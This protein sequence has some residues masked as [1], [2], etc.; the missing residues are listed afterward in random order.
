[1]IIQNSLIFLLFLTALGCTSTRPQ[2]TLVETDLV[3]PTSKKYDYK[4]KFTTPTFPGVIQS[5]S[6]TKTL[7]GG[8]PTI[9]SG[10]Q[11]SANYELSPHLSFGPVIGFQKFKP[12]NLSIIKVGFITR[13]Y[14]TDR[15]G[16]FLIAQGGADLP[17]KR[18]QFEI[19]SNVR[20]GIGYPVWKK[21]NTNLNLSL[22]YDRH[23]VN[24]QGTPAR[25]IFDFPQ[26]YRLES[27]GI[28]F[29][30]HFLGKLPK[31]KTYHKYLPEHRKL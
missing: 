4:I 3:I 5:V 29:G 21:D 22:F 6:D 28:G 19:G 18:S 14:F 7:S 16:L 12:P 20:F 9:P 24:I 10:L 23:F 2:F 13:I 31:K 1:M 25:F 17:A 26:S 15:D 30:I 27:I 8:R 11:L